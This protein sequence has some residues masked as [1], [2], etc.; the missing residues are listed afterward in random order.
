MKYKIFDGIATA[1]IAYLVYG[2][3]IE[4][5]FSNAAEALTQTMVDIAKV[6]PLQSLKIEAQDSKLENLL[7]DFLNEILFCKDSKRM[8][9]SRFCIKISKLEAKGYR[10]N[11]N[12]QGEEIDP[13]KH[14]LKCDVKAVTRHKFYLRKEKKEYSARIVLDI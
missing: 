4:S 2:K 1:D 10:L 12:L 13:L 9:F 6:K 7:L 8:V 5:L 3:K 11:A 14:K